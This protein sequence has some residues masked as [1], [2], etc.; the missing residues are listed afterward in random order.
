MSFVLVASKLMLQFNGSQ[1]NVRINLLDDKKQREGIG[2]KVP[3]KCCERKCK[4]RHT[5]LVCHAAMCRLLAD[6]FLFFNKVFFLC[7][8]ATLPSSCLHTEGRKGCFWV[9]SSWKQAKSCS[10]EVGE[11]HINNATGVMTSKDKVIKAML[12]L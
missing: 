3:T 11:L 1:K 5:L 7:K 6:H 8:K 12:E 9:Y 4:W 10:L 2:P